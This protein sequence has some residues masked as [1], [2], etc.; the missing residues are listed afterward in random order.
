MFPRD[1]N[2]NNIVFGASIDSGPGG[3]Q[4]RKTKNSPATEIHDINPKDIPNSS[5]LDLPSRFSDLEADIFFFSSHDAIERG[6]TKIR[7]ISVVIV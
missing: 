7:I 4:N 1:A 5:R 2:T 3:F 6:D